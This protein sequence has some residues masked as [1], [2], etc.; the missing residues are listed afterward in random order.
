VSLGKTFAAL[1][2]G[3]L[4]PLPGC[5]GGGSNGKP[6]PADQANSL[7]KNIQAADQYSADGSCGR[8]HTKVRDAKF[9]LSHVPDNVDPDVRKGVSDGLNHLDS[10]ISGECERPQNTQTDTTPTETQTTVTETQTT[11]TETTPTETQTTPTQTTLTG[12]T[13]TDTTPTTPTGTGNGGTPPGNG[14]DGATGGTG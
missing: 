14:A 6:I 5:G 9:V 12:T 4:L 1:L 2:C 3:A 7:I 11:P 10:L 13:P 8:A